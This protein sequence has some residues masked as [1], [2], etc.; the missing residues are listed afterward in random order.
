MFANMKKKIRDLVFHELRR[1]K[2]HSEE[3]RNERKTV[4]F[5]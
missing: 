2:S 1:A 5:S 4:L 3:R